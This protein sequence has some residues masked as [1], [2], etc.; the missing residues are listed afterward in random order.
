MRF[1]R[2]L[3]PAAVRVLPGVDM[4]GRAVLHGVDNAP[5]DDQ[6]RPLPIAA[7]PDEVRKEQ[8]PQARH[9]QDRVRVAAVHRDESAAEPNVQPGSRIGFSGRD[10]SNP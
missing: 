1:L 9:P 6:R 3:F 4:P 7:L 8:D 5:D 10:V 2:R